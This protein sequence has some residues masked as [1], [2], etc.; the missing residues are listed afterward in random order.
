MKGSEEKLFELT[1]EKITKLKIMRVH[2]YAYKRACLF[3]VLFSPPIQMQ[4]AEQLI[5]WLVKRNLSISARFISR[6]LSG[7]L[8]KI[9]YAYCEKR[10]IPIKWNLNEEIV[11][12]I[13]LE[14]I[15]VVKEQM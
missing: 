12:L 13:L 1:R 6:L 10:R 3:N 8:L 7:N 2:N 9:V 11:C 14:N 5:E 15:L 4:L